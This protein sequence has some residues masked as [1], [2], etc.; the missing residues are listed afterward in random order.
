M[1]VHRKQWPL[2]LISP[3]SFAFLSS[4][5]E[6]LQGNRP[7]DWITNRNW[8]K[9][10]FVLLSEPTYSAYTTQRSLEVAAKLA[11]VESV[12]SL[13]CR[14]TSRTYTICDGIYDRNLGKIRATVHSIWY[15]PRC[16]HVKRFIYT[17]SISNKR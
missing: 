12:C 8:D 9:R 17:K 10:K 1:D 4:L 11:R 3:K 5:Y 16:R 14:H 13:Y 15:E 7:K 2:F 6:H